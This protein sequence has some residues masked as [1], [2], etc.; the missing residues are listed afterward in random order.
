MP[1]HGHA[2]SGP[3]PW[4]DADVENAAV[5]RLAAFFYDDFYGNLLLIEANHEKTIFNSSLVASS[6]VA[7]CCHVGHIGHGSGG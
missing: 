1:T 6:F 4:R 7:E 5:V 3:I 2:T